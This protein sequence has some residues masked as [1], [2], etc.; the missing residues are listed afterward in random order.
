[1]DNSRPD[2]ECASFRY[3]LPSDSKTYRVIREAL[4]QDGVGEAFRQMCMLLDAPG[5]LTAWFLVLR[6]LEY[7]LSA[8]PS[9]WGFGDIFS[10]WSEVAIW[11]LAHAAQLEELAGS[12]L[13]ESRPKKIR[14]GVTYEVHPLRGRGLK[15]FS[16]FSAICCTHELNEYREPYAL[17]QAQLLIARWRELEKQQPMNNASYVLNPAHSAGGTLIAVLD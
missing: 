14:L 5:T 17:L 10:G 6:N 2:R 13:A 12:E 1:M 7:I 4:A 16:I 11:A 8:I 15:A 9:S 3:P